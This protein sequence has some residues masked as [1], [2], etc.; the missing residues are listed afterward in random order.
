MRITVR[1]STEGRVVQNECYH[2]LPVHGGT[3][4]L[5]VKVH[6]TGI[7]HEDAIEWNG[8]PHTESPRFFRFAKWC[9]AWSRGELS[10]RAE[11]AEVALFSELCSVNVKNFAASVGLNLTTTQAASVQVCLPAIMKDRASQS[12]DGVWA[13]RARLDVRS[14]IIE[15][16]RRCGLLDLDAAEILTD[17]FADSRPN[18]SRWKE[19]QYAGATWQIDATPV[20]TIRRLLTPDGDLITAEVG[21]VHSTR[22]GFPVER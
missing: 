12:V 15:G 13:Q 2:L 10:H 5:A 11:R 6:E 7:V 22:Y 1:H 18:R 3:T 8:L 14:I 9:S 16:A 17:A 20:R 4:F 19:P 21:N